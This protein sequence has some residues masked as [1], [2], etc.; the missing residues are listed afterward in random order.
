MII[1]DLKYRETLKKIFEDKSLLFVGFSFRDQ[2]VN[3]LLQ[4]IL[5]LSGGKTRAHYAFMN[6]IGEIKGAFF[7]KSMNLRVISYPTI[8]GSHI[9][10]AKMI[11]ALRNEFT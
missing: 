8:D 3:L 10:L 11:E 6:D 9:V 5:T 1:K 7:W 2:S 4:E